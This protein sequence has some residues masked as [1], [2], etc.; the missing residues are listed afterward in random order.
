VI[1]MAPPALPAS[2]AQQGGWRVFKRHFNWIAERWAAVG[3]LHLIFKP[4]VKLLKKKN[5]DPYKEFNLGD[6]SMP[7][8]AMTM[9]LLP[10][11]VDK[12]TAEKR[13]ENYNFLLR[14][15]GHL[16]PRP[17]LSLPAGACP[18]AFPLE[19]DDAYEAIKRLRRLGV[20]GILF[21]RNP[22][23]TLPVMDF[24][25]SR[26]FRNRV[27]AVPVHQELTP[28][29]LQQIVE[30]V[31]KATGEE[32]IAR[33]KK[34]VP[35]IKLQVPKKKNQ[36]PKDKNQKVNIWNLIRGNLNFNWVLPL[37]ICDFI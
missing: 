4:L 22:H 19:L 35:R 34:Q 10:K 11:L 16:V 37:I 13:R 2:V 28:S 33:T 24:P 7:P 5:H 29:E 6:P 27:F 23:P 12:T 30:A 20:E 31:L 8:S 26:A 9:R 15:L 17:F 21:W 3:A 32:K 14:H 25:V 36:K 1:S 18:F